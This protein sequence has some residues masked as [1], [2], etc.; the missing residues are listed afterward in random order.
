MIQL[1]DRSV[2][3][4]KGE[5]TDVLI[6]IGE[7]IYPVNFIVIETQPFSNPRSQTPI[8]LGHPFLATANAIINCRNESMRLT[9]RD[10]NMEVNVF[11]L[12][13][14]PCNMNDQSFEVN[15]IENLINEH[16][17]EIKLKVECDAELESEDLSLDEISILQLSRHRAQ[18]H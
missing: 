2:K 16:N 14:Q 12:G 5:V 13:E 10:K 1:V 17:E 6:R 11:N 3:V 7:L 9:L 18:V 15:L 4:S 8:I